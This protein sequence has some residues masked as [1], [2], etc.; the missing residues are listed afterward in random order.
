MRKEQKLRKQECLGSFSQ[1]L[2]LVWIHSSLNSLL[3]IEEERDAEKETERIF[4]PQSQKH[5]KHSRIY[6]YVCV[7]VGVYLPV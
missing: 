1:K 6:M 3:G 2:A 7:Y 4:N 5:H